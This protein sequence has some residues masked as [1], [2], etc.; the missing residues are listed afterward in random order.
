[1]DFSRQP[2]DVEKFKALVNSFSKS[3]EY[4]HSKDDRDVD[5]V[6][7]ETKDQLVN[8]DDKKAAQVEKI[9]APSLSRRFT[10]KMDSDDELEF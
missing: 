9:S 10:A 6:E 7:P 4:D 1:M 2:K 8:Q 5:K 3:I